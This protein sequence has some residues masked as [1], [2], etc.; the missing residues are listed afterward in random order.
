MKARHFLLAVLWAT[1]AVLPL[2]EEDESD[3]DHDHEEH[4]EHFEQAAVYTMTKGNNSLILLPGDEHTEFEVDGIAFM[5]VETS[6]ADEEGLESAEEAA[7]EGM[8]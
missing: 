8:I 3:H 1:G 2:A 6:S 5:V 4:G 7:E